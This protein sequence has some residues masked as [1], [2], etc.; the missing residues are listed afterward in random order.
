MSFRNAAAGLLAVLVLTSAAVG[1]GSPASA[2][3]AAPPPPPVDVGVLDSSAPAAVRVGAAYG[4]FTV[5][6]VTGEPVSSMTTRVVDDQG[7]QVGVGF[8]AASAW[9]RPYN[10]FK[11]SVGISAVDLTGWGRHRL[12]HDGYR[13]DDGAVATGSSSTDIRAHSMLGL[14]TARDGARVRV[15]GSARAYHTLEDRY[16][17]WSGRPVSV[18]RWDGAS[19]VQVIGATTDARGDFSTAVQ[20]PAGSRLRTVVKDT[21]AIWGAVSRS[22]AV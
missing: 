3:T 17:G 9:G 13:W 16:V 1:S 7:E 18:Q 21:P 12:L 8:A 14:A 11:P 10:V 19:W 20:V 15:R 6:V 5:T 4:T 2:A 22:V